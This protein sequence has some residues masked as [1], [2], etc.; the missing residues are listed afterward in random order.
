[1]SFLEVGDRVPEHLRQL[2]FLPGVVLP[3]EEGPHE[4]K[5]TLLTYERR[6]MESLQGAD[7]VRLE[8]FEGFLDRYIQEMAQKSKEEVRL[9]YADF[10]RFYFRDNQDPGR[11]RVFE[12]FLR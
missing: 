12:D 10:R 9:D 11:Q 5:L 1:L 3:G 7:D 4:I 8:P 6:L 2:T